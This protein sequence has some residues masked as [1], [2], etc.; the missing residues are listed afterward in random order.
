M[1]KIARQLIIIVVL[2]PFLVACDASPDRW[3]DW[4]SGLVGGV[5]P[6]APDPGTPQMLPTPTLAP[7]A[8]P[9]DGLADPG[10]PA[11]QPQA[12]LPAETDS[13]AP[14]TG[15]DTADLEAVASEPFTGTFAG[16]IFG[17]EESSA[18][19]Q[20][21]LTQNGTQIRGTATVGEGLIVRAGGLCGSF[22]VPAMTLNA[23]DELDHVDGRELST[24]STIEVNGFEIRVTLQATLAL[25]G[26]TMLAQ[27]TMYPPAFCGTDPT[28]TATLTRVNGN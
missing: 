13:T 11:S 1:Q 20:L 8:Q 9:T 18:A 25:D 14:G 10:Q 16:T 15:A 12:T 4:L 7:R 27:A 26:E 3:Q 6:A 22:D 21:D 24:T 17:D 5:S 23:S 19:L 28:M 2:V